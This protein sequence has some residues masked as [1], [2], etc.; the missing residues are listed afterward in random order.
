MKK[1][2]PKGSRKLMQMVYNEELFSK[3]L[4]ITKEKF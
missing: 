4:K 2:Y 1:L 3:F